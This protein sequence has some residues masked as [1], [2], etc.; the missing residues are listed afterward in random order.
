MVDGMPSFR[1]KIEDP[2]SILPTVTGQHGKAWSLDLPACHRRAGVRPEDDGTVVA[3]LIEA[4]FAHPAWHSYW[5]NIIHL[6]PMPDARK[7]IIYLPGA[8]HEIWLYALDPRENRTKMLETGNFKFL[9]P[10]NF[11]SQFIAHSDEI[12]VDRALRA[13]RR[14]CAG[15]LSPD[16]DWIRTWMHDWGDCMV[17]DKASAGNTTVVIDNGE[18]KV[19][20]VIPARRGPQDLH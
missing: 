19:G 1:V 5:L 15:T 7:T 8:T 18:T 2:I 20:V 11:A 12:A 6:R 4:P 3:W 9:T 17:K 16:T 10:S 14:I 13:V